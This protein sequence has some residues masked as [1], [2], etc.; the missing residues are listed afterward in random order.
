M[1]TFRARILATAQGVPVHNVLHVSAG[2]AAQQAVADDLADAW[3]S[4]MLATVHQSYVFGGVEVENIHTDEAGAYSAGTTG[5]TAGA[6]VGTPLPTFVCASV[7]LQTNLRG[8]AGAGRLGLGPLDE[9]AT[10][11]AGNYLVDVSQNAI[12]NAVQA[13]IDDLASS[14]RDA[15]MTLA[16]VSYFKGVDAAGKPIRRATPLITP[17]VSIA[18]NGVLGTRLS[19]HPNR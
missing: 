3:R 10:T 9:A 12:R 19:R 2:D 17:V 13:F 18:V 7:R 15:P 8:R 1:A 5:P 6:A 11:T 14:T 16:V 4:R